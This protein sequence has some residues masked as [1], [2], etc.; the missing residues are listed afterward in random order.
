V[1]GALVNGVSLAV[2]QLAALVGTVT[3]VRA[4]ACLVIARL[5]VLSFRA[6]SGGSARAAP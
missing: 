4:L 5:F 6:A 3:L 2:V 1:P